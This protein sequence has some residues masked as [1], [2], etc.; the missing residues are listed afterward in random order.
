MRLVWFM[1]FPFPLQTPA[2]H[3]QPN[4]PGYNRE[5]NPGDEG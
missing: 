2:D 5:D 1:W 3:I 4:I